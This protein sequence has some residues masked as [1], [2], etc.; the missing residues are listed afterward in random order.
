MPTRT[1][2]AEPAVIERLARA[3]TFRTVSSR[4]DEPD[5]RDA[6]TAL[7]DFLSH[8]F[9]ELYATA[10]V[11]QDEPWRLVIEL[12]GSDPSLDPIVL[13]AHYDVV[14]VAG[15]SE[16]EW[17][18][19]PWA[20]EIADG[21][22]WGRG[23]LDDKNVLMALLEAAERV[24]RA[25]TGLAR[26]LV[27]AFGGDEELAGRRGAA[28]TAARWSDA[29]RRFHF[30][31]DEG[32]VIAVG[33]LAQPKTPVALIG[34][35]EKGHVN[36]RLRAHQEGGHAAMPPRHTALGRLAAAVVRAEENPF[37]RRLTYSV[38]E[39]L[40]ALAPHVAVPLR[41]VYAHPRLFWPLIRRVLAARPTSEAL[42]R[43]TQAATM[44]NA[45]AAPNVLP[46]NAE[47]V[48]NVRILPGESVASVVEHYRALLGGFGVAVDVPDLEDAHDP[49]AGTSVSHAGYELISRTA[50]ELAECVPAPYLVTGSTDSKW[51]AP[52]ADAVYRFLP[53][54]L[55]ENEIS[56]IHG[57]DERLSLENYSRL[58]TFY[59]RIILGACTNG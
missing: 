13:M 41:T 12:P 32:A 26:G 2:E 37:P 23:A 30:V 53:M 22:V 57:T 38:G 51:Y 48:F 40:R 49:V 24:V 39:F 50:R 25:G 14:D 18:H 55:D 34:V 54:A 6:Y 43:S 8:S 1:P 10:R 31:L 46:Q 5:V 36:V 33:M 59:E 42:I 20:G 11:E 17:T 3:L 58:I 21:F 27:L 15:G 56:R 29:G 28:V 35:E 16:G 47:A 9:P 52:L 7:L 4:I 44:A 19:A 45:S